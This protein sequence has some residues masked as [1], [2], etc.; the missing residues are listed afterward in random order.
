[1][2]AKTLIA[3]PPRKQPC[4]SQKVRQRLTCMNSRNTPITR[5]IC[6]LVVIVLLLSPVSAHSISVKTQGKVAL[7]VILGGVAILTKYLVGR[8]QQ[9]VKAVH[10]KLGAPE[11]I[12]KFER[13]FDRWRVE[14]YGNRRYV[15]RNNILEKETSAQS[16]Q[17]PEAF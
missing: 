10:A 7:T 14:W 4:D 5:L 2:N 1:M 8:D 13:G 6:Y 9:A 11:R 15:F 3:I 12:I 17:A 16:V